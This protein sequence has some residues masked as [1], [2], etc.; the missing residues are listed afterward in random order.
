MSPL[1]RIASVFPIVSLE[2]TGSFVGGPC[3]IYVVSKIRQFSLRDVTRMTER[4]DPD[5][6]ETC[7]RQPAVHLGKLLFILPT[8]GGIF[9]ECV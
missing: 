1:S 2:A 8:A 5:D 6:G 7:P 4:R 3:V 9:N